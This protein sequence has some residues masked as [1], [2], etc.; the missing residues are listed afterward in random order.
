MR[1]TLHMPARRI[2][3]VKVS[4]T[5]VKSSAHQMRNPMTYG[6]IVTEGTGDY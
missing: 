5:D 6:I 4:K 2:E 3:Y 1:L